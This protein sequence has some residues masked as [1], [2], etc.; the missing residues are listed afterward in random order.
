[1]TTTS[2]APRGTLVMCC[3]FRNYPIRGLLDSTT[4]P[5]RALTQC[6]HEKSAKGGSA[7][8]RSSRL[9]KLTK[10]EWIKRIVGDGMLFIAWGVACYYA[11]VEAAKLIGS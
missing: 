1:M 2:A 9:Q 10:T 3:P 6:G 8:E 4:A 5:S 11:A 7:Y